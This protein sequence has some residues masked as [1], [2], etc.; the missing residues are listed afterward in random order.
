MDRP[1]VDELNVVVADVK[2]FIRKH[3]NPV[4]LVFAMMIVT[5]H[6]TEVSGMPE[7]RVLGLVSEAAA[8]WRG[9]HQ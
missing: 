3:D 1:T 6:V 5:L 4:T 7:W 9:D 8:K 2:A